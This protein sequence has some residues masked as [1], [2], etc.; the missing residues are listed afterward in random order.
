[1]SSIVLTCVGSLPSPLTHA[2]LFHVR[3]CGSASSAM[4]A[5]SCALS[6]IF[7]VALLIAADAPSEG[8]VL[9]PWPWRKRSVSAGTTLTSSEGTPSSRATSAA[10]SPSRPSE[11]VVRLS[12]I[13]PVGWTRRNTARYTGSLIAR[14]TFLGRPLTRLVG[15]QRVVVLAVAEGGLRPAEWMR[16]HRRPIAAG[17]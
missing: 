10:Y 2:P 11:S 8:D 4:P 5:S 17:V 1:M 13:L 12:T 6:R 16:R 15:G 14:A 7:P 9:K 3:V